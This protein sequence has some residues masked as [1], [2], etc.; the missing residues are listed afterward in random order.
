MTSYAGDPIS[1]LSGGIVGAG[2]GTLFGITNPLLTLLLTGGCGVFL[3]EAKNIYNR[4]KYTLP[5]IIHLNNTIDK[6]S[7]KYGLKCYTLVVT[8]SEDIIYNKL[9]K[10]LLNKYSDHFV[11]TKLSDQNHARMSFTIDSAIFAKPIIDHYQN[12]RVLWQVQNTSEI[13]ISSQTLSIDQLRSYIKEIVTYKYGTNTITVHQPTI[14]TV[15]PSNRTKARTDS[16][17]KNSYVSWKSFII[18]TN[19]TLSNTILTDQV[20]QDLVH[21]MKKFIENDEEY[22]NIKGIPYKRGYILHGPPG[23]GKTSILK[24][25]AAHYNMD[26]FLINMG[27]I[28]TEKELTLIF[29]GTR[30]C[31][32]YHM[33][34]FEDIDRCIL[35]T[36]N[37]GGRYKDPSHTS[38][39]RTFLNELDGVLEMPKRIT[40]LTAND[41]S[42]LENIPALIRP[43]RIDKIV[44]LNYC[45]TSQI[46]RIY[47]HF[48]NTGLVCN[49]SNLTQQV[50][51][52]QVIKYI[53]ANPLISPEELQEKLTEISKITIAE[54]TLS[55]NVF[56]NRRYRRSS[57]GNTRSKLSI[58]K[59]KIKHMEKCL[60]NYPAKIEKKKVQIGKL[61]EGIQKKK[62]REQTKKK[63][64]KEK[65][66]KVAKKVPNKENKV[67]TKKIINTLI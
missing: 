48:S 1:L 31:N 42:L 47:N 36:D 18:Q 66:K 44:N 67:N 56:R 6:L 27:E 60:V 30:M 37:A 21:D 9:E 54:Q 65:A 40:V 49:I 15:K 58:Y 55:E 61:L 63:R 16:N 35:F 28:E 29:Q 59:S 62:L 26:I 52:A 33:L 46:N 25:L 32:D 5:S 50:T 45:D 12:H 51:P 2:L 3:S 64:E 20:T 38:T 57:R 17:D 23:T 11:Y 39:I 8:K 14:E 34:V 19:K 43:G 24:A 7:I 53:L 13:H 41:K 22:C 10:Y 4:L